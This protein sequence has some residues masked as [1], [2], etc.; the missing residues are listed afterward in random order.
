MERQSVEEVE[1]QKKEMTMLMEKKLG[2]ARELCRT[3]EEKAKMFEEMFDVSDK[4][5]TELHRQLTCFAEDLKCVKSEEIEAFKRSFNYLLKIKINSLIEKFNEEAENP[6][7]EWM[8]KENI[9]II[10]GSFTEVVKTILENEPNLGNLAERLLCLMK[11][12]D[13]GEHEVY[14][15]FLH[16][17]AFYM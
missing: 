2:K 7:L 15:T 6:N 10:V 9:K 3:S 13:D 8:G 4:E 17:I 12:M 14:K 1:K 16:I 5:R 11:G